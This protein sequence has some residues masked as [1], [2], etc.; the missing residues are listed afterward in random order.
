M[1]EHSRHELQQKLHKK[2][3]VNDDIEPV[4]DAL[5]EQDIQ[6]EYRFGECLFRTRVNKGFGWSYIAAEL[7]QKGLANDIIAEVYQSQQIDWFMQAQQAYEKRFPDSEIADAKA[8]AQRIRF[9]QYRGFDFEQI[10]AVL[11]LD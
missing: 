2:G 11:N 6:N 5:A 4:L 7:K 3:F 9:L 1:R 8:K 10:A